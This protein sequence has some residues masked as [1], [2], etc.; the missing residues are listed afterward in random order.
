MMNIANE[1]LTWSSKPITDGW[2][3]R[4][5]AALDPGLNAFKYQIEVGAGNAGIITI[6][7]LNSDVSF[8]V[9]LDAMGKTRGVLTQMGN[10]TGTVICAVAAISNALPFDMADAS[11]N[12]ITSKVLGMP[13]FW[14]KAGCS[15]ENITDLAL[16]LDLFPN[17][18]LRN[19]SG[20]AAF[21]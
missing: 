8:Q 5:Q 6:M 13:E 10:H 1:V 21:F 7:P 11:G 19:V 14:T 18:R 20:A 3:S 4:V 16:I 17:P 9:N 15:Y 2:N 12:E